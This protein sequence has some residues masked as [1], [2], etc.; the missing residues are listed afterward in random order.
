M[1]EQNNEQ[2]AATDENM[3]VGHLTEEA[4]P[5]PEFHPDLYVR[6]LPYLLIGIVGIASLICAGALMG[7]E[8]VLTAAMIVC[9]VPAV[10]LLSYVYRS[11]RLEPEPAGLLILLAILGALVI[12]PVRGLEWLIAKPLDALNG[13]GSR[14]GLYLH[15]FL[16]AAIL[17]EAAKYLVLK[18]ITWKHSAFNYCFDGVV[19]GATVAIGFE[20]AESL[21]YLTGGMTQAAFSRATVPG[22]CIFGI[23]MGLLY[24]EARAREHDGDHAGSIRLQI[25]SILLPLILHGVYDY[26]VSFAGNPVI[27]IALI[28]F[29]L[30]INV[31]TIVV[32]FRFSRSDRAF[33]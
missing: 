18:F 9:Y 3:T 8:A 7:K 19:Y 1:A 6:Y 23:T 26:L 5:E 4:F 15:I 14:P 2:T 30:I 28:A 16:I 17:E 21:L 10:V 25:V 11:D 22:H 24:G 32:V 29:L 12:L 20:I 13:A 31:A 27:T 33:D